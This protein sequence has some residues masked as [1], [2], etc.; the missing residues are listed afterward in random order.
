VYLQGASLHASS[1]LAEPR[2]AAVAT[3]GPLLLPACPL[4]CSAALA[5]T[6]TLLAEGPLRRCLHCGL[7]LSSCTPAQY[8][9]SLSIWN[10]EDGTEP[11]VA[12]A[13][14]FDE[15]TRRRLE[16]ARRLAP[17]AARPRLLDVGCS[18]GFLLRVATA[19]GFSAAGVES[20]P[21][22]A[23]AARNAGFDVFAG[24]LQEAPW[25][26]SS[27]EI[28]TLIELIEHVPDPLDLL[29]ACHR[30]LVPGGVVLINT[31]NAASW[32]ARVMRGAWLGFNLNHM[33]GHICFYSPATLAVAAQ[34]C[35]FERVA[36]ETRHVRFA[37]KESH[38]A[39]VYRIGKLASEALAL[40]ARWLNAGHD[41][42]AVLRRTG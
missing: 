38:A 26:A 42:L 28:I 32:T 37:E 30:L 24:R 41:L 6:S 5:V 27:F 8:E 13:R 33:G 34:R 18:S 35:G 3:A 22:A 20:A 21:V 23:E 29:R 36:F 16:L 10:T 7:M 12:S 40:P 39:P 2:L 17:A 31:P 4:G 15:V 25:P 1:S 14:R 11:G 19:L 9:A